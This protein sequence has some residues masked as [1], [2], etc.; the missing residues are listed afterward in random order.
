MVGFL[1]SFSFCQQEKGSTKH[2]QTSSKSF[3]KPVAELDLGIRVPFSFQWLTKTWRRGRSKATTTFLGSPRGLSVDIR[4][5]SLS[6]CS[7]L[8]PVLA[9]YIDYLI[10]STW[11]PI[12]VGFSNAGEWLL[13]LIAGATK[14][15]HHLFQE[16]RRRKGK[17]AKLT[18]P[19]QIISPD[20]VF[21]KAAQLLHMY[22][23]PSFFLICKVAWKM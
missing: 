14:P 3:K 11:L 2:Y 1:F 20:Q 10:Y 18:P 12:E 23:E 6:I 17:R 21:I 15:L 13:S 8:G 9:F 22:F 16:G 5:H 7:V 4:D 19:S